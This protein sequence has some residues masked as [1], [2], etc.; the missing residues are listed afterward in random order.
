MDE[1]KKSVLVYFHSLAVNVTRHEDCEIFIAKNQVEL[2]I[3]LRFDFSGLSELRFGR[4]PKTVFVL[5][6]SFFNDNVV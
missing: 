2:I 3:S 1:I 5:C 6:Q 4:V